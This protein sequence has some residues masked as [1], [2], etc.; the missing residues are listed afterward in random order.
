MFN[1]VARAIHEKHP[2]IRVVNMSLGGAFPKSAF[3]QFVGII[4]SLFNYAQLNGVTVVVSAGNAAADLDHN[5][6]YGKPKIAGK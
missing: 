4:N 3:G 6:T 2:E 5:A 1:R